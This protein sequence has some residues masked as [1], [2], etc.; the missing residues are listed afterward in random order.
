MQFKNMK[1]INQSMNRMNNEEEK[2]RANDRP[3]GTSK[4]M[5]K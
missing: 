1:T 3:A 4:T 2:A 5:T